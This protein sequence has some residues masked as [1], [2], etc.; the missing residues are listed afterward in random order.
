L[1]DAITL[2][3]I[4][5]NNVSDGSGNF[6]LGFSTND[7][8]QGAFILFATNGDITW[9]SNYDSVTCNANDSSVFTIE[10]DDF[11]FHNYSVIFDNNIA[12]VYY[13]GILEGSVAFTC[14][15]TDDVTDASI[16][17]RTTY[18]II[19]DFYLYGTLPC[20]PNWSCTGYGLCNISNLRPC[21]SVTDLNV[22]GEAYGGDYSEFTPQAC[23]VYAPSYDSEDLAPIAISGIGS[24][25]VVLVS[26]AG[27]MAIGVIGTYVIKWFKR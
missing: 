9:Q 25:L 15:V 1:T 27:I 8:S 20:T 4:E 19:S 23:G 16:T 5:K 10:A 12:D 26:F 2:T 13:D 14:N 21:T 11:G 7:F 3:A 22:C 17:S 6:Q 18:N 24:F